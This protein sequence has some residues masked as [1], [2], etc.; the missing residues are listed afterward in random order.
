M[1]DFVN[2]LTNDN[3]TNYFS[4]LNNEKNYY[5]QLCHT[6]LTN[7][8]EIDE[9]KCYTSKE[10]I[11]LILNDKIFIIDSFTTKTSLSEF[12]IL[13][14]NYNGEIVLKNRDFGGRMIGFGVSGDISG[15]V[16]APSKEEKHEW[17]I[18]NMFMLK[19]IR[20]NKITFDYN[21]DAT[22]I[23]LG[24]NFYAIFEHINLL[25]NAVEKHYKTKGK[26]IPEAYSSLIN[27]TKIIASQEKEIF[28]MDT[29][30]IID[31]IFDNLL[32]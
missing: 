27:K 30:K 3:N 25:S 15:Y 11:D 4:N 2:N 21:N 32:Q 17:I 22:G 29:Q 24:K 6:I 9:N 14:K 31:K 28:E 19:W 8:F 1:S 12:D 7:N 18:K 26:K 20:N 10:I 16:E 23:H 13:E 5:T